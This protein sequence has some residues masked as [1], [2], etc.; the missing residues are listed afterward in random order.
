[1]NW[2]E[3][4]NYTGPDRRTHHK[5]WRLIERRR[6]S[7]LT[8]PPTLPAALRR[9]R[10]SVIDVE[11]VTQA[12]QFAQLCQAMAAR[13]IELGRADI[14]QALM[15]LAVT[16]KAEQSYPTDRRPEIDAALSQCDEL[17]VQ[18]PARNIDAAVS[19]LRR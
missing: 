8:D 10:L 7:F 19:R 14:A 12:E 15:R 13:A 3:H 2:V 5:G 9:L 6:R 16:L 17:L 4:P 11:T 1:M 18:R